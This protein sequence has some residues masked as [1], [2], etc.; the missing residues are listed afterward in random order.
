MILLLTVRFTS[1]PD[2]K[3]ITQSNLAGG[4]YSSTVTACD[5]D[6]L[7]QVRV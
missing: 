1:A 5:D 2:I 4:M 7:P 6:V 3:C